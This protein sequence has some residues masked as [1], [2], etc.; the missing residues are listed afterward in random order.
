M[1]AEDSAVG[2]ALAVE[3]RARVLWTVSA[4]TDRADLTRFERS[5]T[6]RGA[7]DRL[8]DDLAPST[9]AVWRCPAGDLPIA[10]T[11]IRHRILDTT[12]RTETTS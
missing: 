5:S 6:H 11:D 10:W 9:F 7:K 4:W 8:R 2:H 12:T 3:L 1:R